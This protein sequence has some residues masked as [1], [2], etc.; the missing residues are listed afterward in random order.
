VAAAQSGPND[1]R[2]GVLPPRE[3]GC[4]MHGATLQVPSHFLWPPSVLFDSTES[5]PRVILQ[6]WYCA[7]LGG[8]GGW[9]VATQIAL[10]CFGPSRGGVRVLGVDGDRRARSGSRRNG[11]VTRYALRKVQTRSLGSI[12]QIGDAIR[13]MVA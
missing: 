12:P 10:S 8:D 1:E 6:F 11:Q 9:D 4:A 13:R 3:N 5:R 2:R 7:M